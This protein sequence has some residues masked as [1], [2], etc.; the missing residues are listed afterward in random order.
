MAEAT[1]SDL[2]AM[3]EREAAAAAFEVG[4]ISASMKQVAQKFTDV[5]APLQDDT[6]FFMQTIHGI[7]DEVRSRC[8]VIVEVACGAAPVATL[9]AKAA[10]DAAVFASDVSVTALAAARLVTRRSR[11]PVQLARMSLLA[12]FRPGSVDLAL[13]LPPYLASTRK[14]VEELTAVAAADGTVEMLADADWIFLGGPQGTSLLEQLVD[15]DLGRVLSPEGF[16]LVC[17]GNGM[18]ME[19]VGEAI[20][21]ASSGAFEA[22]VVDRSGEEGHETTIIRI[23]RCNA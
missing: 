18:S 1:L 14:S 2:A 23:E 13:I 10:P 17:V 20:E 22:S 19:T 7:I 6:R 11:A 15:E 3:R 9:L 4:R 16:A 12:A 5:Y 21:R 8:G